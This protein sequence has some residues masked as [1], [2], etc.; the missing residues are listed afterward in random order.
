M[1]RHLE[2]FKIIYA[3]MSEVWGSGEEPIDIETSLSIYLENH[4]MP[5]G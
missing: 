1:A 5:D 2:K 4:E 3:N